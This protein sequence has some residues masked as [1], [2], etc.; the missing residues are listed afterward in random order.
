MTMQYMFQ[1][2]LCDRLNFKSKPDL[3]V[4]IKKKKNFLLIMK[5]LF[6]AVQDDGKI[7]YFKSEV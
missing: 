1:L 4:N 2:G 6:I 3:L 5:A 7:F